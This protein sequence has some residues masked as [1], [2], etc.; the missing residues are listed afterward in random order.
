MVRSLTAVSLLVIGCAS[1]PGPFATGVLEFT[2]GPDATF[3]HAA[4]PGIVLG[5]PEGRGAD[6]GSLDVASL[7]ERGTI[8]L[9]FDVVGIDGPGPDL[10]V[11]ENPFIGWTETGLVSVSQDNEVWHAWTEP[12]G[13]TPVYSNS[14]NGIDPLSAEAGGDTFDLLDL[15]VDSFKYVR[16]VDSGENFYQGPGGGF[17]LDAMVLLNWE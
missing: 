11:F 2:P 5:P 4:L 12:A 6:Q 8:V 17:D 10:R 16:V 15:P 1:A 3:G 14:E 13:L 7:G 9:S